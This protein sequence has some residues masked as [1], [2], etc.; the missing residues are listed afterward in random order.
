[1]TPGRVLQLNPKD[2]V[3]VAL[4]D[5]RKGERVGLSGR[6]FTLVTDVPAKHKFATDAI[7]PGGAVIM[8]GVLIGKAMEAIDSEKN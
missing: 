6:T 2:N 8:Y 3:L 7:P 1:M 4:Q 5:L